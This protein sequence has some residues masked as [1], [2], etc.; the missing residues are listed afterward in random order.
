MSRS[1][2]KSSSS[3]LI[4][5]LL[6]KDQPPLAGLCH[7]GGRSQDFVLRTASWAKVSRPSGAIAK[8]LQDGRRIIWIKKRTR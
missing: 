8:K 3:G 6:G 5:N 2:S 1:V 7:V 4:T